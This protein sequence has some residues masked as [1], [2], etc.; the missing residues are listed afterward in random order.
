M[1]GPL[2]MPYAVEEARA[3][4]PMFCVN[5]PCGVS[6]VLVLVFDQPPLV[7]AAFCAGVARVEEAT[8]S[9]V[10]SLPKSEMRSRTRL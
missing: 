10:L 9:G 7:T 6:T 2:L 4:V 5:G 3:W 8:G 1:P